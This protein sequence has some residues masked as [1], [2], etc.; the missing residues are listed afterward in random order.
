MVNEQIG[1]TLAAIIALGLALKAGVGPVVMYLTEAIK[2]ALQPP[3]GWGGLISVVTGVV[4]GAAMGALSALVTDG[5]G[6][7]TFIAFGA[8]GGLFMASGAIETHKAAAGINVSDSAAIAEAEDSG[9]AESA[10]PTPLSYEPSGMALRWSG[11]EIEDGEDDSYDWAN[12][13]SVGG[14]T[15]QAIEA[16]PTITEPPSEEYRGAGAPADAMAGNPVTST[17][18]AGAV[19]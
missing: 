3:P 1:A 12:A 9:A 6:L 10:T 18:G 15:G 16:E 17:S 8:V 2:D 19:G 5:T 7:G 11:A 13:R 14:H 4:L